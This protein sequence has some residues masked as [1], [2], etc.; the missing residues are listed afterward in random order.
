[1]L[2]VAVAVPVA[3]V[4]DV[5]ASGAT[6]VL[7]TAHSRSKSASAHADGLTVTLSATPDRVKPRSTVKLQLSVHAKHASGALDYQL[8][9][10]DGSNAPPIVIPEYCLAGNPPPASASWHFSHIYRSAGIYDVSATVE[11]NCGGGH[12]HVMLPVRVR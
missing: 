6:V 5:G 4:A 12:V 10:G 11:V 1:L 2:A 9:Y 3:M 8:A 7:A